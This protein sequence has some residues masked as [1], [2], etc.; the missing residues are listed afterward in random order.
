MAGTLQTPTVG[1]PNS[2]EEPKVATAVSTLN[3]L[4]TSSNLLDGAQ[5]GAATVPTAALANGAVGNTQMASGAALANL[6]S[7][8][9]TDAK[10]QSPNNSAYRTLL[11][12][13]GYFGAAAAAATYALMGPYT[14]AT[15]GSSLLSN[16]PITTATIMNGA[17]TTSF[18][19][20]SVPNLIYFDDADYT[21]GSLTQKLRI[22]AQVNTNATAWSSVTATFGLYP[23]TFAGG[24]NALTM[25]LGTVVSG[26][27]VAIANPS[28][29]STNQSNSGDFTIPSDGQ[30]CIGV[31]TSATLTTNV[32]SL[33]TAQLQTRNV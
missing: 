11:N 33:L 14:S 17:N 3:G 21:V 15:A 24:S 25:T 6:A 32:A 4:L 23:V 1:S 19:V 30:F 28:A 22:R 7:G 29:S 10:L 9:V 5:L 20:A 31:V 18:V 27:T 26:S 13:S 8:S 12:G 16:G 2:S